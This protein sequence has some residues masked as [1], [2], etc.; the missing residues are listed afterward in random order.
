MP[1]I[2]IYFWFYLSLAWKNEAWK[3]KIQT[4]SVLHEQFGEFQWNSG[5]RQ[6][7][8]IPTILCSVIRNVKRSEDLLLVIH[9][10]KSLLLS[11]KYFDLW[12]KGQALLFCSDYDNNLSE[13][14][15]SVHLLCQWTLCE[16]CSLQWGSAAHLCLCEKDILLVRWQVRGAS[17]CY[18]MHNSNRSVFRKPFHLRILKALLPVCGV[19]R[20]V[21]PS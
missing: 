9:C 21:P 19:C 10:M 17:L 5:S 2:Y 15:R 8:C 14:D 13:I 1:K 18:S 7:G 6:T 3:K 20:G 12:V 11:W 4:C 16:L